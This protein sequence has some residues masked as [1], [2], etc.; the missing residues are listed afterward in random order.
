[1]RRNA[2]PNSRTTRQTRMFRV[3]GVALAAIVL[4]AGG[5]AIGLRAG[6]IEQPDSGSQL[7][8]LTARAGTVVVYS[9][10]G[11]HADTIFAASPAEP[12]DRVPIAVVPHAPNFG[13]LANVS[14][15]S[16]YVALTAATSASTA[17]LWLLVI[18]GGGTKRLASGVDLQAPVWTDHSEALVV[19]RSGSADA[20]PTAELLRVEVS[21]ETTSIVS[22]TGALYPIGFNQDGALLYA[23]L[24][25]S[26]TDLNAVDAAGP[27]RVMALSDGIARDW[28]LSDDGKN[29]AYLAPRAAGGFAAEVLDI[30][31]GA[32]GGAASWDEPAF[33]PI[34]APNGSLT[35]GRLRQ[36]LDGAGVA[37]AS[38][39]GFDV[40]LSWSPDGSYLI[41]RHFEG[42]STAHPGPSWLWTI[43]SNGQR[44][45]LS[46]LS[47]VTI[48]GWLESAH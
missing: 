26:G 2:R 16:R 39:S 7:R 20:E 19:S 48:A 36:M 1:M 8:E 12:D 28:A 38:T 46:G 21:G 13:V 40:P 45:K 44:R 23:S 30:E 41:I 3:T 6:A 9:E 37:G 34:W 32:S 17:D 22:A 14:P 24:D 31:T 25:T 18:D 15:D 11:V 33:S 4:A 47:D 29:L 10:F 42:S 5:L 43:D 27:R 35:I